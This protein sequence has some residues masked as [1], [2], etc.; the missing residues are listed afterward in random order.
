[1]KVSGFGYVTIRKN[2]TTEEIL[3]AYST[4][5][6][7]HFGKSFFKGEESLLNLV[8]SRDQAFETIGV[9]SE[10]EDSIKW[11][12][13]PCERFSAEQT[14]ETLDLLAP[15]AVNGQINY[16]SED[17]RMWCLHYENGTFREYEG[18]VV[19]DCDYPVCNQNMCTF[20]NGTGRCKLSCLRKELAEH[21]HVEGDR[22]TSCNMYLHVNSALGFTRAKNIK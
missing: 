9:D 14:M 15:I 5:V 7:N 22:V 4:K 20:N 21:R 13:D 17:G 10:T 6:M 1:M 2:L 11:Y 12:F 3:S 19:F 16:Y 8:L 18:H